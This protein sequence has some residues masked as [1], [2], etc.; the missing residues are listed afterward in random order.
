MAKLVNMADYQIPVIVHTLEGDKT[1]CLM[2]KT[3]VDFDPSVEEISNDSLAQFKQYLQVWPDAEDASKA[4]ENQHDLFEELD[5]E[6]K[7]E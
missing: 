5:A 7:G 2:P 3:Y 1:V 4:N 6:S